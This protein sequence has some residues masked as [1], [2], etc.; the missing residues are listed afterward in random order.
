MS[1][2]FSLGVQQK[3]GIPPSWSPLARQLAPESPDEFW[4]QAHLMAQGRP[5]ERVLSSRSLINTVFFGPPGCGKT[6]LARIMAKNHGTDCVEI[7]CAVSGAAQIRQAIDIAGLKIKA[8]ARPTLLVLDE[9]H[10]LNRTQQDLLLPHMESGV[11]RLVGLTTEN[12]FFYIHRAILSRALVFEFKAL[13]NEELDRILDKAL[14]RL[15]SKSMTVAFDG[16]GRE[17]LLRFAAGDARKL[18]NAIEFL[19]TCAESSQIWTKDT[20]LPALGRAQMLYDKKEDA[21]YDTASA[22]IKSMRGSDPDA[23]VYWMAKMIESGEDPRFVARRIVIAASEDVGNA[24]PMA[25]VVAQSAFHAVE[26]LGLPEGSIPLAQAA[27]YVASAPKSNASYLAL[28]AAQKQL[29][30]GPAR[31]VPLHL[32]DASLDAALGHGRGYFYAHDYPEHFVRQEYWPDAVE[33]YRPTRQGQEKL[34]RERL[35]KFWKRRYE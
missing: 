3:T 12:P 25:L 23:A 26:L 35:E 29:E 15:A 1:D 22:F 27:I 19:S 20:L 5:L 24:D 31:E 34:L 4:G 17:Y 32:K 14:S 28:K 7:S 11:I 10:H 16:T 6:S 9:I 2:L 33:L 30:I 21:H 13:G 18:L 8:T